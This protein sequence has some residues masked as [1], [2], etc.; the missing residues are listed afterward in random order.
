M[1]VD[2]RLTGWNKAGESFV[3]F[4]MAD[5]TTTAQEVKDLYKQKSPK[6]WKKLPKHRLVVERCTWE[7]DYV[8]IQ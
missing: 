2:H 1:R 8:E 5:Q 4:Q 3:A 6:G 7:G